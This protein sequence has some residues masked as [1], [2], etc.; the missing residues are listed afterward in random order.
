MRRPP[1]TGTL[2]DGHRFGADPLNGRVTIQNWNYGRVVEPARTFLARAGKR[3]CRKSWQNEIFGQS[4]RLTFYFLF[5]LFRVL[6]LLLVLLGN[7]ASAGSELRGTLLDSFKQVLP[8]DASSLITNTTWQL[9]ARA[10]LRRGA[11][12]AVMGRLGSPE[13][14]LVHNHRPE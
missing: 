1:K 13:W 4:A 8:P 2:C 12:L 10:V 9:N 11:I 14:N 3:A 6:L 7:F 5:A